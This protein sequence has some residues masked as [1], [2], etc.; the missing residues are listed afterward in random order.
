MAGRRRRDGAPRR[1][2]CSNGPSYRPDVFGV[3]FDR[4]RLPDQMNGYD[5]ACATALAHEDAADSVQRAA[6]DLDLH[7]GSE[8]RMGIEGQGA[9]DEMPDRL[10]LLVR[11]R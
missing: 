6:D 8:V 3:D 7:T 5:Q 10:D 9:R 2:L 11:N 4:R 1:R